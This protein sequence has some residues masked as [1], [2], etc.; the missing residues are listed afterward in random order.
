MAI[1]KG[2]EVSV[3]VDGKALTEYDDEDAANENSDHFSEV[4]KYI[5]A[6]PDAEFSIDI[7]MSQS[8]DLMADDL[9]FRLR[10]DGVSVRHVPCTKAELKGRRTNW[11]KS[12]PGSKVEDG[13]EC[14][15]RPFKFD[16]IKI[17][18]TSLH[19]LILY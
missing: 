18:K 5:E 11:Y 9:S 4:S 12:I 6:I 16:A 10:L 2:I 3:V 14:Y 1:L 19:T 13:K 8:Y 7:T 17:G 15:L